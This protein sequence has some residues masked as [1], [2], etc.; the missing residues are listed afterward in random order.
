MTD[1]GRAMPESSATASLVEHAIE[2]EAQ[3]ARADMEVRASATG[4]GCDGVAAPV[5]HAT[6]P[7]APGERS[8]TR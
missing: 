1:A 8:Q 3:E 4:N 5:V 2:W 6:S 7:D